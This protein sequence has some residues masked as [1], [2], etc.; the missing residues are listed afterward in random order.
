MNQFVKNQWMRL[1]KVI[2]GSSKLTQQSVQ[3]SQMTSSLERAPSLSK[4]P[5]GVAISPKEFSILEAA[6]HSVVA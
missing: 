3:T 1:V 4:F 5:F 6:Y 2:Q